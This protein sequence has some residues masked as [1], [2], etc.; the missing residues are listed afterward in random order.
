M[1]VCFAVALS[2]SIKL[3][4]LPE[5]VKLCTSSWKLISLSEDYFELYFISFLARFPVYN[6]LSMT[7]EGLWTIRALGSEE[8]FLTGFDILQDRHTAASYTHIATN[9]WF[10]LILDIF[11]MIFVAGLALLSVVVS[12]NPVTGR[13]YSCFYALMS[14]FLI[15]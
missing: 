6:H 11:C 13:H 10:A 4:H 2:T 12:E 3:L 15:I 7:L 1:P 8:R 14:K 9:R 5:F